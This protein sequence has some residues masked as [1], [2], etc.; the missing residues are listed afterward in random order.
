MEGRVVVGER[1]QLQVGRQRLRHRAKGGGGSGGG[2][3]DGGGRLR[4]GGVEGQEWRE[5]ELLGDLAPRLVRLVDLVKHEPVA[6]AHRQARA[7]AAAVALVPVRTHGA[8]LGADVVAAAHGL[9]QRLLHAAVVVGLQAAVH[10]ELERA[11]LQRAAALGHV[12]EHGELVRAV[13]ERLHRTDRVVVARDR[14]RELVRVWVARPALV[15]VARHHL[16]AV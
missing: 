2:G 7:L 16:L 15:E 6:A 8:R 10:H 3:G 5:V 13:V 9:V 14:L 1:D 4:G 11:V 12:G